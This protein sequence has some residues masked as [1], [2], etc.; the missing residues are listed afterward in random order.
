MLGF[1]VIE[2]FFVAGAADENSKKRFKNG[3]AQKT[4]GPSYFVRALPLT[5]MFIRYMSLTFYESFIFTIHKLQNFLCRD[6]T[7]TSKLGLESAIYFDRSGFIFEVFIYMT[8][9]LFLCNQT[10]MAVKNF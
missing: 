3:T 8:C 6:D 5:N 7:F 1:T 4:F 9:S 10:T 2:Y